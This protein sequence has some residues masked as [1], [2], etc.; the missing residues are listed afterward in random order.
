MKYFYTLIVSLLLST[1]LFS[2]KVNYDND[3]RWFWGLNIGGTWTKTDI[4]H[5]LDLG[6]GLMLGRQFNYNY[7]KPI[8][9]DLRLRYL[10]GLWKG[11]NTDSTNVSANPVYTDYNSLNQPVVLNF[12]TR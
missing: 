5:K 6:Y 1:T 7:G 8:S 3:S 12:G 11:Y 4:P 9:F 10:T 2:Q